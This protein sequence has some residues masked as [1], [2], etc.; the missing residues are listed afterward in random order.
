MPTPPSDVETSGLRNALAAAMRP[1][2]IPGMDPVTPDPI[3]QDLL[4]SHAVE[5]V[6]AAL[7]NSGIRDLKPLSGGFSAVV[8]V[9]AHDR[10]VRLGFG[11][12]I[13]RPSIPQML[14]AID[15]GCVFNI[16][17]EILPLVQTADITSDDVDLMREMLAAD[18]YEFS[19]PGTDN[20]G[21]YCGRLVV[22][23]PG[24]VSEKT[25]APRF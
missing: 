25:Y 4:K 6:E 19:D 7:T 3:A 17:W 5:A 8:L 15:S 2:H 12:E 20:L 24:A 14:Q 13:V 23:D 18:G 16:Q 10:V 21:I 22:I 1:C 9:D 11:E